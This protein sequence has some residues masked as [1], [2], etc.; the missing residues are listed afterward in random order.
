LHERVNQEAD[1]VIDL[2]RHGE[3]VGGR[4]YRGQ[5]DDPLSDKGWQ[6]MRA[7]VAN[8]DEWDVIRSST[9]K[10][11]SE[12]AQELA[13]QRHLSLTLDERLKEIGFGAWEGQTAEQLCAQDPQ[14]LE[15]FWRDPV[16]HRPAGAERLTD[17]QSRV[18]A[19]WSD[20]L[21]THPGQRVLVVG[22]AGIT[23]MMVSL[24]LGSPIENMF[25]IQVGNAALTR[26]RIRGRGAAA[27][28]QLVFHGQKS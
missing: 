6:Q 14:R 9:L 1:T 7:A 25:R 28:P 24:A 18:Q 15:N 21:A 2:L 4:R 16:T 26:L 13:A 19:A 3:P 8:R 17:F 22:H 10:R 5:I 12:F 20:I 23:R 11:C 27:L